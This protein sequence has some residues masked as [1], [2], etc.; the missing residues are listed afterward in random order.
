MSRSA[1]KHPPLL[2]LVVTLFF[3]WG[4]AT[5]L[6]DTLVPKL[7]SLFSLSYAEVLLTQF[8]FFISY[9]LFSI[10]ASRLLARIG[11]MNSIVTGLVITVCGCLLFAP[12]AAMGLFYGFLCALFVMAAGIT[13]LQVTANPLIAQLGHPDRAHSRLNLAQAFNSLGTTIGPLIGAAMILRHHETTSSA[14]LSTIQWP[15]L[16]IAA[17]LILLAAI[18]WFQR[19]SPHLPDAAP[20]SKFVGWVLLRKPRVAMGVL[21]I[22]VYVGAEVSIGSLMI[23][24]LMQPI[25]LGLTAP[26]AGDLVS[27]YWGGAMLG[28]FA[29]SAALIFFPAGRVLLAFAVTAFSLVTTSSLTHGMLAAGTLLAVGLFNS[30][31]FPTIFSLTLEGL[32]EDTPAGSGLLCMAIVGGAVIPPLTGL[33]ADRFSLASA[34]EIPAFCYVL[35]AIFA[36]LE[37]RFKAV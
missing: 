33:V 4:L 28:R 13:L 12:A 29:G 36:L 22:F 11:Y 10:P 17:M 2:F 25:T 18:F 24:D 35:I 21:A 20:E 8:S 30:I 3:S 19:H 7:R 16:G 23:S 6:I 37:R 15:F 5:V 26:E 14:D 1:Q 34:L 27:L 9:L 32:G 31:M